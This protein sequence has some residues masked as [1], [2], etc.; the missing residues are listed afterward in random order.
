MKIE[1]KGRNYVAYKY[2]SCRWPVVKRSFLGY[3]NPTIPLKMLFMSSLELVANFRG[4]VG[5]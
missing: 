3:S 2:I 1:P 4:I 5:I